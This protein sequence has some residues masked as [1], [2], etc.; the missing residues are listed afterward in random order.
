MAGGEG[1]VE[2]LLG[3]YR[4][5]WSGLK[6]GACLQENGNHVRNLQ[7]MRKVVWTVFCGLRDEGLKATG[8]TC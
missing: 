3:S 8:G 7:C 2:I 1:V 6:I 4:A 5:W